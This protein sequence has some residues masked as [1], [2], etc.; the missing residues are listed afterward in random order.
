MA[1]GDEVEK[2]ELRKVKTRVG[3]LQFTSDLDALI[4]RHALENDL[5]YIEIIGTLVGTAMD[6]HLE[7]VGV[8]PFGLM[9]EGEEGCEIE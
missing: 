6:Q 8:P 3:L 7:M 4:D 2:D 1:L 9:E 5:T